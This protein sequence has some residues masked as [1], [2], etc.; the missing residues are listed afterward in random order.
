MVIIILAK[1]ISI[2]AKYIQQEA[3]IVFHEKLKMP[4]RI[5]HKGHGSPGPQIQ[6]IIWAEPL[7]YRTHI[8]VGSQVPLMQY[9]IYLGHDPLSLDAGHQLSGRTLS[10]QDIINLR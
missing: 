1:K 10:T 9:V 3:I 5:N 6:D 4:L 2:I 7:I 8:W